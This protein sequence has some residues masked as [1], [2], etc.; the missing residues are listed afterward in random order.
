M[1]VVHL[2]LGLTA[3]YAAIITAMYFAQTWLLF[4]TA[5]AGMERVQLPASSRL[6]K[7]ETPDGETLVGVRIP[8]ADSKGEAAATLLGFGG[9]AMCAD[10]MALTLHCLF[11]HRDVVVFNYRGYATSTGTPSAKAVLSDSLMIFERLQQ[12]RATQDIV[13]VGFSLGTAIAAYLA[14]H[15][16]V[17]GLILVAPFDSLEALARELYWWGPVGLLL[18]HRMPTLEFVHGVL[19]P[20]A[21]IVADHD[22]VVPARRSAP[23]RRAVSNPV[24]ARTIDAGHNDLYDHPDFA[25]AMREDRVPRRGVGT[26]P[27]LIAG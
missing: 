14:R 12:A 2:V 27:S 10:S 18:R 3:L 9:N 25:E 16:P 13:A 15:R 5:L 7:V 22:K 19:A 4:P 26:E 24:F 1:W 20:T 6:L 21:V 23:L 11:P 8:S 17:T